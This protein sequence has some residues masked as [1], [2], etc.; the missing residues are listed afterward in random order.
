MEINIENF[1]KQGKNLSLLVANINKREKVNSFTTIE[2]LL[3][4]ADSFVK[5][6]YNFDEKTNEF[7]FEHID[8]DYMARA[9]GVLNPQGVRFQACFEENN[10]TEFGISYVGLIK[11]LHF[12]DTFN[13]KVPG[14]LSYDPAS[15]PS[16][17]I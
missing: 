16:D 7:R 6:L 4:F 11:I 13:I 5:N 9:F 1:Q 10:I 3:T 17:K 12:T 2:R 14:E 8:G 15:I